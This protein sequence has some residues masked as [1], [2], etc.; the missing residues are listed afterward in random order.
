MKTE[1][2]KTDPD[3]WERLEEKRFWEQMESCTPWEDEKF[4]AEFLADDQL[5]LHC[6]KDYLL[7]ANATHRA[8]ERNSRRYIPNISSCVQTFMPGEFGSHIIQVTIKGVQTLIELPSV[9]TSLDDK[10][11]VTRLN[12]T[13]EEQFIGEFCRSM[14]YCTRLGI[15]TGRIEQIAGRV[16]GWKLERIDKVRERA[17]TYA[18]LVGTQDQWLAERI[19]LLAV[20]C[21]TMQQVQILVWIYKQAARY[22]T[23][24]PRVCKKTIANQLG[25]SRKSVQNLL[26]KLENKGLLVQSPEKWSSTQN[27]SDARFINLD[28]EQANRWENYIEMKNGS[29]DHSLENR[30]KTEKN[31]A[32]LQSLDARYIPNISSCVQSLDQQRVQMCSTCGDHID[33]EA[34]QYKQYRTRQYRYRHDTCS[35]IVAD[36][37]ARGTQFTW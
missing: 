6:S 15:N 1:V 36:E 32:L 9:Q 37:Q 25:I 21:V 35:E 3:L 5:T 30:C 23:R 28:P 18:P 19:E 34:V 2:W 22:N 33:S 16:M 12:D 27:R 17:E 20:E 4:V 13:H 14:A 29:P 10:P 11:Y 31:K 24:Q 7:R 8:Y 26:V